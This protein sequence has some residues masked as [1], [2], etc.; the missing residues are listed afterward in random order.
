MEVVA[1]ASMAPFRNRFPAGPDLSPHLML[2]LCFV[3]ECHLRCC[4]WERGWGLQ[5]HHPMGIFRTAGPWG[6]HL[7]SRKEPPLPQ[8]EFYPCL[9]GKAS[10]LL[11]QMVNIPPAMQETQ[12]SSLG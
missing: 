5:D 6:G 1:L 8:N 9:E 12:V 4:P 2:S 11:A 10:S 7:P 3:P